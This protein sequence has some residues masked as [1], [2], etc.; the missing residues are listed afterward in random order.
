VAGDG[1]VSGVG[2]GGAAAPEDVDDA[3]V[4]AAFDDI[5]SVEEEE[6]VADDGAGPEFIV[7]PSG[8]ERDTPLAL[9]LKGGIL[10]H[11]SYLGV[12]FPVNPFQI[13]NE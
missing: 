13:H 6:G 10:P 7:G 2:G 11:T 9:W 8:A 3:R 1:A 5:V 4:R 12:P